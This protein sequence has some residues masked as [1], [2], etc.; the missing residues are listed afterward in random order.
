MGIKLGLGLGINT[1][2]RFLRIIGLLTDGSGNYLT[3]DSGNRLKGD[4]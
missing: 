3:D 2:R 1:I 4:L